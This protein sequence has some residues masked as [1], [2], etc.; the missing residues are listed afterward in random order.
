MSSPTPPCHVCAAPELVT[1]PGYAVLA[2]VTSDCRPWPAGG[3]LGVCGRCGTVQT[4]VDPLWE[5]EVGRI[6]ADYEIYHQSAGA[7]Q[8]VFDA[9]SGI[10]AARSERLLSRLWTELTLPAQGRLLDVGC[11]N[12]ALL[13]GCHTVAPGWELVGT[14]LSDQHRAAVAALPGVTNFHSGPAAEVPGTFD[15]VTMSHVL[16]HIPSPVA[17]LRS[18]R[19]R[20]APGGLLVVEVPDLTR[21]PFDLPVADHATHFLPETAAAIVADAGYDVLTRTGDWVPKETTV[22]ARVAEDDTDAP[23][24]PDPE[25]ALQFATASVGWLTEVRT[26]ARELA[27]GGGVGVFGTSIAAVW[28]LAE[29]GDAV[30][31]FVDEDP[32]RI[33][34]GLLGRPIYAPAQAPPGA[35]VFLALPPATAAAVAA[36]AGVADGPATYH[37]PPPLPEW[38]GGA[39]P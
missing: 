11:G 33:G 35:S 6:Y 37:L 25:R 22:V 36:H 9:A 1:V 26:A 23:S 34:R 3:T 28:L 14:E 19:P 30:E 29:L 18:L 20:L 21:N 13:R 38:P 16:E 7:E 2:R 31:F 10:M 15:L 24:W 17:F 27:P 39:T 5:A 32:Q 12:G 4:G 8:G